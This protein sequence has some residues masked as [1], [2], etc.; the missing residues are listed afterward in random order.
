MAD[1]ISITIS[2][3]ALGVSTVTAWFTLLRRGT[4]KMTQPTVIF[5]GPDNPRSNEEGPLPVV[6]LRTLLFSTSKRGRVIE[7]MYVAGM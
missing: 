1:P 3:L 2:A 5:F 6:Y 4:I 7:C